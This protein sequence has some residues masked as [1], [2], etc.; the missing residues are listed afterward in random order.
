MFIVK[1]TGLKLKAHWPIDHHP[2]WFSKKNIPPIIPAFFLRNSPNFF[3]FIVAGPKKFLSPP[4][5]PGIAGCFSDQLGRSV[6]IRLEDP[7]VKRNPWWAYTAGGFSK[8]IS[9]DL[10][11]QMKYIQTLT[12]YVWDFFGKCVV[13]RWKMNRRQTHTTNYTLENQHGTQKWRFGMMFLS[14]WVFFRFHLTPEILKKKFSTKHL[15]VVP[16]P[17][18]R[19]HWCQWIP[20]ESF[21]IECFPCFFFMWIFCWRYPYHSVHLPPHRV[22]VMVC[23]PYIRVDPWQI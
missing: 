2:I 20:W 16:Y 1:K 17:I 23:F 19:C 6:I 12:R 10:W 22:H 9:N 21:P 4:L 18:P 7:L 15:F 8:F 11:L 14:N 5:F 13:Q 3:S